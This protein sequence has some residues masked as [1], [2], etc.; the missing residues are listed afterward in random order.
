MRAYIEIDFPRFYC[1]RGER[2]STLVMHPSSLALTP[3]MG[4]TRSSKSQ[5]FRLVAPVPRHP[6][7]PL[8]LGKSVQL[9]MELP[10]VVRRTKT[11]KEPQPLPV[12]IV[13]GPL[14][15][16]VPG[17]FLV[18]VIGKG[19][20]VVAPFSQ[21]NVAGLVG[22]GLPARLANSLIREIRNLVWSHHATRESS[23]RRRSS[24][25]VP[26]GPSRR[27]TPSSPGQ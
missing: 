1:G 14:F 24:G 21:A 2:V 11:T 20:T 17:V 8:M 23:S 18:A 26:P 10:K 9:L 19:S 22:A 15:G 5:S 13:P 12:V 6:L 27:S 7:N 16:S 25:T 4:Y 3:G